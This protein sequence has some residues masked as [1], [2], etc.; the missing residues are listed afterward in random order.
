MC[1]KGI[2]FHIVLD[3]SI[4]DNVTNHRLDRWQADFAASM[5]PFLGHVWQLD[6][7]AG[8]SE[9]EL[10]FYYK[11]RQGGP[12]RFPGLHRHEMVADNYV[13]LG[14]M[15]RHKV[16][17]RIHASLYFSRDNGFES[18]KNI[19]FDRM[20]NKVAI[21]LMIDL[22][23]GVLGGFFSRNEQDRELWTLTFAQGF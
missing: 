14:G 20:I 21:G 23:V 17:S 16:I 11:F 22:P 18:N 1:T 4:Y 15:I 10:P 12:L 5:S 8:L 7:H 9:H 19:R 6:V 3:K 13:S 2:Y